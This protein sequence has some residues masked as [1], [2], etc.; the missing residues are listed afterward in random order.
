MES[1]GGSTA[2]MVL[3]DDHRIDDNLILNRAIN[4]FRDEIIKAHPKIKTDCLIPDAAQAFRAA[5]E[6]LLVQWRELN[7]TRSDHRRSKDVRQ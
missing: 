7:T 6:V 1:P 3:L 4:S 5:C 2:D